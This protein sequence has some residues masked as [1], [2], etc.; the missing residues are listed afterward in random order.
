MSSH[1]ILHVSLERFG[2]A[3]DLQV[4]SPRYDLVSDEF[5][6]KLREFAQRYLEEEAGFTVL[7]VHDNEKSEV[8]G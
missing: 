6:L 1:V 8:H 4:E 2:N 7:E 5:K 3:F